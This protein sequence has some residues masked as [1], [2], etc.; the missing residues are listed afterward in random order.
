MRHV[1]VACRR[2]ELFH[3]IDQICALARDQTRRVPSVS[4]PCLPQKG[5]IGGGGSVL[6]ALVPSPPSLPVTQAHFSGT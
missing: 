5:L 1:E 2:V 3:R 4:S 6:H